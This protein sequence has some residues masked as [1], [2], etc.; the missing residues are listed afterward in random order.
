MVLLL[1]LKTS[2]LQMCGFTSWTLTS[3][4]LVCMSILMLGP[5]CPA[6]PCITAR[7][8]IRKYESSCFVLF[9]D[10]PGF[11]GSL[12]L[13]I[14]LRV[15]LSVSTKKSLGILIGIT[16]MWRSLSGI[17]SSRQCRVSDSWSWHDFPYLNLS[18]ISTVFY[19]F[20]STRFTFLSLNLTLSVLFFLMLLYIKLFS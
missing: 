10:S 15:S 4:L 20:Q 2:W 9:R 5:Y 13:Y 19:S 11:P 12:Y 18:C 6:Y 1:L 3:I 8:E 16:L 14:D 7:P 17:R